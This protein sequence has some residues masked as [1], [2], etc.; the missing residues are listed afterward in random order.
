MLEI[1]TY[2]GFWAYLKFHFIDG[3]TKQSIM[4]LDKTRVDYN[5]NDKKTEKIHK[6]A[7]QAGASLDGLMKNFGIGTDVEITDE[8]RAREISKEL[9]QQ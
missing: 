1:Y 8:Q 4:L 6:S 3:I 7:V 2:G 5:S 9:E